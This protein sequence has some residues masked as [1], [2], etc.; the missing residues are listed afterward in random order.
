MGLRFNSAFTMVAISVAIFAQGYN[1]LTLQPDYLGGQDSIPGRA[2]PIEHRDKGS[3]TK[4]SCWSAT[5][6]GTKNCNLS[7]TLYQATSKLSKYNRVLPI[8]T[9]LITLQSGHG[10]YM[11]EYCFSNH[12]IALPCEIVCAKAGLELFTLYWT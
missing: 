2:I 5:S 10:R 6:V 8:D 12:F 3:Q 1:P 11:P 7:F 9:R 4:F